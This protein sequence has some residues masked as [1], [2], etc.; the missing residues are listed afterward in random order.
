MCGQCQSN[1]QLCNADGKTAC[2]PIS[3]TDVFSMQFCTGGA[4]N[5][6]ASHCICGTGVN[7]EC[8]M[9]M[10]CAAGTC[11]I[12][13]RQACVNSAEC[14]S[15]VCTNAMCTPTANGTLCRSNGPSFSGLITIGGCLG[16]CNW[17]DIT[18]A[19]SCGP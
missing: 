5:C 7:A 10:V 17:G 13:G 3:D 14:A 6:V 2:A 9:G 15:G 19:S 4:P 12:D 1:Q 18:G 11:K 8:P 16:M